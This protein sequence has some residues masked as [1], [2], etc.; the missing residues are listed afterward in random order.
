MRGRLF[1]NDE[2]G[3]MWE[4]EIVACSKVLCHHLYGGNEGKYTSPQSELLI[5][6]G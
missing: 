6:K 1:V 3:R 2:L 4:E 5:C